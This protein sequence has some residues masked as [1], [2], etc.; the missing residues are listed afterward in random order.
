MCRKYAIR[1]SLILLL[2]QLTKDLFEFY[3]T[4]TTTNAQPFSPQPMLTHVTSDAKLI[5][6]EICVSPFIKT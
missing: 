3:L 1:S 5:V 6:S 2:V 4:P